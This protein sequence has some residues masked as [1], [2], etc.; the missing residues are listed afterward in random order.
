MRQAFAD[1][2]VHMSA[3]FADLRAEITAVR[4]ELRTEINAVRRDM[5]TKAELEAL[6][7][8]V[9]KIAEGFAATNARLDRTA[10]LILRCVSSP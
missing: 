10:D 8:D 5:A 2:R 6:R 7:E 3:G 4:D 9:K 1:L